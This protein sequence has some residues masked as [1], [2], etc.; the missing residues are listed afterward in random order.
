MTV[1]EELAGYIANPRTSLRT[2]GN[3]IEVL[4]K[5]TISGLNTGGRVKKISVSGGNST[6]KVKEL[7]AEARMLYRQSL[8]KVIQPV[9][10]QGST[11]AKVSK[12][13]TITQIAEQKPNNLKVLL[14]LGVLWFILRE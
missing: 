8:T 10:A 7:L 1:V 2:G 9:Q 4:E 5:D 14:F 13:P 12:Q 3:F 11:T 6:Q